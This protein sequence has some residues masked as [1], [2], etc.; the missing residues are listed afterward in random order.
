[1]PKS[2][3]F[4]LISIG[5]SHPYALLLDGSPIAEIIRCR[6]PRYSSKKYG[7]LRMSTTMAG[8]IS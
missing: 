1:M 8:N 5:G 2:G 6:C 4:Y 3:Q 7:P